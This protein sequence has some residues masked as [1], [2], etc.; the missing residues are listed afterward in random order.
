MASCFLT[1]FLWLARLVLL[2]AIPLLMITACVT[3]PVQEMSDARQ[4]IRSAEDVGATQHS[5][6]A[7]RVAWDL[8]R[9]AQAHLEAGAYDDARQL[10]LD[11]RESAIRAHQRA[12]A[13]YLTPP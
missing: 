4:S 11:A 2:A 10:A 3:P 13:S 12:S 8:L 9:E 6:D 7:M 1:P 5:P